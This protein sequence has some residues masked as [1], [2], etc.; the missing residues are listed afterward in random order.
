MNYIKLSI[1]TDW[2]FEMTLFVAGSTDSIIG[3]L[4]PHFPLKTPGIGSDESKDDAKFKLLKISLIAE[5]VAD[6]PIGLMF[7]LDFNFARSILGVTR[8]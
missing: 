8:G 1:G 3:P 5:A 6:K 2:I 4:P 7:I